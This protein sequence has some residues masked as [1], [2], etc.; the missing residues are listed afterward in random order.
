MVMLR[1]VFNLVGGKIARKC[2]F[3]LLFLP[4]L[5]HAQ[6]GGPDLTFLMVHNANGRPMKGPYVENAMLR[7]AARTK[8]TEPWSVEI[9]FTVAEGY[10]YGPEN[11]GDHKQWSLA[12][13]EMPAPGRDRKVFSIIDCW[14]TDLHIQVIQADRIMRID[15]PDAPADRWAL[16]QRVMVRSGDH[17][18]PEV[19]RFRV[20]RYTYAELADDPAFDKLEQ[21]IAD[22]LG[23]A[24]DTDYRRQLSEQEKY[25]NEQLQ[26]VPSESQSPGLAE[27]GTY[28]QEIAARPALK[29]L[30]IEQQHADTIWLQITGGVILDGGCA[31]W[32]PQFS[33]E[34]LTDGSWVERHPFPVA[35]M[36]CGMPWAE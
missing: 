13:T 20:G 36:D 5:L 19:F 16:V 30:E 10:P 3:V 7:E 33:I 32:M 24:R 18:S 26:V 25:Y 12:G 15:L 29:V 6:P 35:Q 9:H 14:C 23:H 21:R 8:T 27:I 11:P 4:F 1:N 17:P 22:G 34:M 2:A 31:S 28:E